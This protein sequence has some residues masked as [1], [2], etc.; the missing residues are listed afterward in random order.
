MT[1]KRTIDLTRIVLMLDGAKA[2]LETWKETGERG[3]LVDARSTTGAAADSITTPL[4]AQ[5]AGLGWKAGS[6]G[7][8]VALRGIWG[9]VCSTR[10]VG[11]TV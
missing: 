11:S 2:V 9:L 10:A 3:Q 5:D 1:T 7:P 8:G 6:F 4:N